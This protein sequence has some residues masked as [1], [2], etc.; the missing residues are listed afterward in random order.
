MAAADL[1]FV[2]LVEERNSLVKKG[3]PLYTCRHVNEIYKKICFWRYSVNTIFYIHRDLISDIRTTGDSVPTE[4]Q[5]VF[6]NGI[7][8]NFLF[9]AVEGAN[10][11][12]RLCGLFSRRGEL[13]CLGGAAMYVATV[14]EKGQNG[15]EKFCSLIPDEDAKTSCLESSKMVKNYPA[16]LE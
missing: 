11:V 4:Y 12:I 8:R 1:V 10:E 2:P 9:N 5:E 6:W 14:L 13:A 7:G 3:D 15:I 16:S